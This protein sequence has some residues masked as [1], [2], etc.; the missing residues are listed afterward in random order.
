MNFV[1][2]SVAADAATSGNDSG[3][4]DNDGSNSGG[5]NKI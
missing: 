3:Y 5:D 1:G 4:D 2:T